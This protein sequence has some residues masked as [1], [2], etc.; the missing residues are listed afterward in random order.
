MHIKTL[1]LKIEWKEPPGY[2]LSLRFCPAASNTADFC[3][4]LAMLRY[5]ITDIFIPS[6]E[7]LLRIIKLTKKKQAKLAANHLGYALWMPDKWLELRVTD[8]TLEGWMSFYLV[9]Y[10]DGPQ[11]WNHFDES[12]YVDKS[13]PASIPVEL[14]FM[15][16]PLTE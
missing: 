9:Y 15:V 6:D 8:A 1:N 3:L 5:G 7:H 11:V 13:H 4:A 16:P 2:N 10:R 14:T 12:V